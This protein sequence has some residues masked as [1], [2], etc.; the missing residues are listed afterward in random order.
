MIKVFRWLSGLMVVLMAVSCSQKMG[1]KDVV[2]ID[3]RVFDRGAFFA[4]VT[5]SRFVNLDAEDRRKVVDEFTRRQIVAMEAEERGLTGDAAVMKAEAGLRQSIIVDKVLEEEVWSRLVSD[6]SLRVLYDRMGRS[7]SVSHIVVTFKGAPRSK[8]DRREEDA[9]R[10]IREIREKIVSGEL[11]FYE[12][13]R[14]Y[15]EAPSARNDGV[16]GQFKWGELFEPVQTLAFSTKQGQVSEPVRSRAGY[17]IVR[18]S[19]VREI[20]LSPYEEMIPE[21]RKSI[22][23][24]KGHEF[25]VALEE[26]EKRLERRYAVKF[27]PMVVADI[28]RG[29]GRAHGDKE[30]YPTAEMIQN[31][32]IP[33]IVAVAGGVPIELAWFREQISMLGE[34]LSNSLILSERTLIMTLEHVL[35]RHLTQKFAEQTREEEWFDDVEKKVE[36][37]RTR[38]LRN[39]L[40]DLLSRE[41]PDTPRNELL[42]QL[43]GEHRVQVNTEFISNYRTDETKI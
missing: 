28:L 24:N 17:H 19:G 33:G 42:Q 12:A 25:D 15:S 6:S 10:I 20:P 16:L 8:T 23:S 30:G 43:V 35:Y 1:E 7:V 38:I 31:I 39:V 13:A 26:F 22:R 14:K 2:S 40:V 4:D 18:V 37:S 41:W 5:E 9:L 36:G 27:N 34:P 29:I 32:N 21:L 11:K 3:N